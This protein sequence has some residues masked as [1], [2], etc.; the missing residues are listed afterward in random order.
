MQPVV[1]D[2]QGRPGPTNVLAR[3]GVVYVMHRK[4]RAGLLGKKLQYDVPTGS[5]NIKPQLA[6]EAATAH[7]P[8]MNSSDCQPGTT[9]QLYVTKVRVTKRRNTTTAT[10]QDLRL[11]VRLEGEA[12]EGAALERGTTGRQS[13]KSIRRGL[14]VGFCSAG[15]VSSR[16]SPVQPTRPHFWKAS[17]EKTGPEKE[18]R[19]HLQLPSSR[20]CWASGWLAAVIYNPL[21]SAPFTARN[22]SPALTTFLSL[23]LCTSWEPGNNYW[24]GSY[25][26]S[27]HVLDITNLKED[28][29]GSF[30]M[31]TWQIMHKANLA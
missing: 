8:C 9:H 30:A 26:K 6:R 20:L 13:D 10:G 31:I 24:V 11:N 27:R 4:I 5:V 3:Q 25:Q 18:S 23:S 22:V 15:T 14:W 17:K 12:T 7:A 2:L 19:P 29:E 21:R 1:H 16:L 28:G